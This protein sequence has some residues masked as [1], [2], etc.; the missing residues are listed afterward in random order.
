MA[1]TTATPTNATGFSPTTLAKHID[2]LFPSKGL[3]GKAKD[4]ITAQMIKDVQSTGNVIPGN[5]SQWNLNNYGLTDFP[6]QVRDAIARGEFNIAVAPQPANVNKDVLQKL[7]TT[8][9]DYSGMTQDFNTGITKLQDKLTSTSPSSADILKGVESSADQQFQ[10]YLKQVNAPSSVDEAM[11]AIDTQTLE[12]TLAD[13]DKL[14]AQST[15]TTKADMGERGIMGAGQTSSIAENALAQ[16]RAGGLESKSK[17]YTTLASQELQR[18]KAKEDQVIKAYSD[19]FAME[20]QL[21]Q[22]AQGWQQLDQNYQKMVLDTAQKTADRMLAQFTDLSKIQSSD[23][24]NLID[25][26]MKEM[27]ADQTLGFDKEKLQAQIDQWN[28]QNQIARDELSVKAR[29][30]LDALENQTAGI[31]SGYLQ[32]LIPNINVGVGYTGGGGGSS[33]IEGGTGGE[34]GAGG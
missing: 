2:E 11:K 22:V 25:Q 1:D 24:Q 19:R 14:V 28:S 10:A 23:R 18:Q 5:Y 13:I 4:D 27:L 20:P 31:T 17:A 6:A 29:Q 32:K 8:P 34:G 12:Q 15:A 3:T 16:V 21:Q 26:L 7:I 30:Q 9:P 33:S